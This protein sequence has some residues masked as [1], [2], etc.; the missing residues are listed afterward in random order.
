MAQTLSL[1]LSTNNKQIEYSVGD[2][3]FTNMCDYMENCQYTCSLK[4]KNE[5]KETIKK[6]VN[7]SETYTQYFLQNN[8]AR[9]AKRIRQLFRDKSVYSF[10]SFIKEINIIKPFPLEQIY[11]TISIFL[12]NKEWIVDKKE[13]KGYLI[14]RKDTYVFQPLE[15][16]N[17]NASIFE[18]TSFVEN[19]PKM[20]PIEIPKDPIISVRK[21]TPSI[22]SSSKNQ[23]LWNSL[24]KIMD[25]ILSESSYIKPILQNMNWYHYTK[26][27]YRI[28]IHKHNI[29]SEICKKYI[30][31]H[32]LDGLLIE[33]KIWFLNSITF[34]F[35]TLSSSYKE[36]VLHYFQEKWMTQKHIFCCII[37]LN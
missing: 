6:E 22:T 27:A 26:L 4:K 13:R 34:S 10:H 18:R 30:I 24:Q 35:K 3:P 36:Y 12:N 11:Y 23:N 15:I 7:E 5:G 25:I 31:Y 19:K 9:I 37:N 32:Y 29:P 14:K 8:Y 1:E 21:N 20:I 17:E 33:E 16:K 28:C 2:K